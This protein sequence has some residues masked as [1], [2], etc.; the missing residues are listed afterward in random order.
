MN[1][2]TPSLISGY[3]RSWRRSFASSSICAL[4][5]SLPDRKC[6]SIENI[7]SAMRVAPALA[8]IRSFAASTSA[9]SA[10]Q[11]SNAQEQ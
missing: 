4:S 5:S 6:Q 9:A 2:W 3:A 1:A 8:R 7:G 10:A 11:I